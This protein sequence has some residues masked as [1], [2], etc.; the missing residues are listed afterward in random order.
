[1]L[2]Y[3]TELATMLCTAWT[4]AS[5]T[6]FSTSTASIKRYQPVTK[7]LTDL[8]SNVLRRIHTHQQIPPRSGRH[9]N[10]AMLPAASCKGYKWFEAADRKRTRQ[11][12]AVHLARFRS[13]LASTG[14]QVPLLVKPHSLRSM[15]MSHLTYGNDPTLFVTSRQKLWSQWH[16]QNMQYETNGWHSKRER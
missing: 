11:M 14:V 16:K 7:V 5:G 9:R 12:V 10:L 4:C 8:R 6:K 3:I 1:M 13:Q 2:K 15:S